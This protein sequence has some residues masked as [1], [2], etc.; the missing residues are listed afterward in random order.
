MAA[1]TLRNW[2]P[3]RI[4]AIQP[5]RW[6]RAF[7]PALAGSI[8]V[9]HT[10]SLW[11]TELN[12]RSNIVCCPNFFLDALVGY[13]GLALDEGLSVSENLIGVTTL[14]GLN[15]ATFGV[16][17]TFS[18][19]NR[20]YGGQVGLAGQ[21]KVNRWVLDGSLKVA[22]GTTQET[23]SINGGTVI[24]GQ[25]FVGGLLAQPTNIGRYTRDAFTVVPEIGLTVGYQC[26]DHLR[27]FVGY[28]FLYWSE[29]ARP[30][31][32][33]DT[34][35]DRRQ[36]A[37]VQGSVAT[38]PAGTPAPTRPSFNFTNSDYWAQGVTLGMQYKW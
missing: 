21:Y 26:T 10:S 11:G 27:C 1:S 35:I 23:V 31:S 30:G 4:A 3:T 38:V 7:L 32:S 20:F 34:V 8:S 13:R 6:P 14:P 25:P 5:I 2:S 28:N 37:T 18:T 24:N 22:L 17:D 19:Q 15:G 9:D 16:S 29:V 36:L 33:V 12:L